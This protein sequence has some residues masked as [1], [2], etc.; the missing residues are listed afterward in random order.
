MAPGSGPTKLVYLHDDTL[1]EHTT[2]VV[3]VESIAGLPEADRALL[4]NASDED[5]VVTTEETVFYVQGGGQP[6]DTGS[7]TAGGAGDASFAVVAVRRASDGRVLHFGRFSGT[8][9][10]PGQAVKQIVDAEKRDLHSRIHDA[11]HIVGLA[12]RQ[13]AAETPELKLTESKAQHYPGAA[14]VEFGGLIDGKY[15]EAIQAKV[16]EMLEKDLPVKAYWWTEAEL[17]EKCVHVPPEMT[18]P[19]GEL[20]RAVDICVR[21]SS[22][23]PPSPAVDP[24]AG[25]MSTGKRPNFLIV[26]ADDLGFSDTAPYGG[27]IPTPTLDRLA[28][29]GITMTAFHTASA[30]SPTRS[31]LMSGTDNH[32]AGL[33]QMAE[34]MRTRPEYQG[35][36]GYEGYLNFRVAA[37]PE[38]LQDNGYHTILSGKW[39]LGLKKE[40]SPH[41]RGFDKSFVYLAGAGNHYNN[42][43]QLGDHPFRQ[44]A[45]CGD[46]LWMKDDTLLDREKDIPSDFYSTRFF[47]DQMV[48]YLQERT[49]EEKEKPFFAYLAYTAPHWPLQ[50]PREAIEKHFGKYDDGPEALRTKRLEQLKARGLVPEDVEPA[51]MIGQMLKEWDEM[52]ADERTESARRMETYAAMVDLM[53]EHLAKVIDQLASTN[54]LD[55]TF[56]LF[57]SDN[58]AEGKLLEALPIMAGVP[59]VDVI[60]KFYN[61]SLENIGNADS[62]VWYGP[63]WAAAATAPSRGF[64]A[65]TTEGGI[66][67]PCIVRYPPLKAAGTVTH[68][69]TTVMDIL[70]TVLDLAGI[71]HPGTR[72]RGRDV[73]VPR[74]RSWVPHLSGAADAVH[75]DGQD[76]TGW[77]LFGQ[78]AIRKGRWKAVFIPAPLGK[79]EWELYDID[80][81]PGEIHDLAE[82]EPKILT[83]LLEEWEKYFAETGMFDPSALPPK[84]V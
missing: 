1:R 55:N 39:H 47:S 5:H 3:S 43:P 25:I 68:D 44:P 21:H 69:F 46:G 76:V 73:V 59:L 81:D 42:E 38:I 9:F 32:I 53:D 27:E 48:Q 52:N 14:H 71:Q 16:D 17:R 15:K 26:I 63:R 4:K 84:Y 24:A 37:L 11:G 66:R 65:W 51:P 75:P 12:V 35:K 22:P 67:C 19:E 23:G 54:E 28:R 79:E 64:K 74:G 60:K 13:V 45:T 2:N 57:M 50:A 8:A 82:K 33:G 78:R 72:F 40:L 31:M 6:T 41:A 61:N 34:F 77:E 10:T 80:A 83:E 70:P 49:E 36:P 58:G 30:C 20:L 29:E 18:A 7:M 56:V 62:F